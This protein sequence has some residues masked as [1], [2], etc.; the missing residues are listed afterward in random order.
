MTDPKCHNQNVTY[1]E[2]KWIIDDDSYNIAKFDQ[3]EGAWP[4]HAPLPL[5]KWSNRSKDPYVFE[6]VWQYEDFIGS[7][8]TLLQRM[9]DETHYDTVHNFVD[10]HKAYARAGNGRDLKTF[11]Q[12][13][14]IP[15]NR[16]HHMCVSLGMEI[17]SRLI[18]FRKICFS[19]EYVL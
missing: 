2:H 6:K 12:N 7:I 5:P 9:L 1:D 14:H 18:D 11:F 17:V 4:I 8:E 3:T 15:I 19:W 16:R 13:Y 10:F